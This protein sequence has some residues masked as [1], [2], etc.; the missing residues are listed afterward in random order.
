M[1]ELYLDILGTSGLYRTGGY[2]LEEFL[3]QLKGP[4]GLELLKEFTHNNPQAGAIR[5]LLHSL[6]R[7]VS[8][9]IAENENP[10]TP[11]GSDRAQYLLEMSRDDMEHSWHDY[12]AES[13]SMVE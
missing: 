7:Q 1:S 3:R 13:L 5:S 4:K 10:C 9:D 6:V 12:I 11:E 2:I 8:W